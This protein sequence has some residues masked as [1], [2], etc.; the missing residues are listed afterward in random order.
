MVWVAVSYRGKSE[1]AFIDRSM[2][3]QECSKV[4]LDYLVPFYESYDTP[5]ELQ[6]DN[7]P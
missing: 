5:P 2:N 6:H 7:V 4:L 3:A 1:L